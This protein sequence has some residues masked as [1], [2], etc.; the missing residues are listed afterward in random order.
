MSSD[1]V[2]DSFAL[3]GPEQLVMQVRSWHLPGAIMCVDGFTGAD[4]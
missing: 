3:T 4:I 2:V 1:F